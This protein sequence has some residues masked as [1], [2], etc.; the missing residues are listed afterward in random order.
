MA[1]SPIS[2]SVLAE[3]FRDP[4]SVDTYGDRYDR[5]LVAV[6]AWP[7]KLIQSDT[8]VSEVY[9]L[10]S[11]PEERSTS[12]GSAR[13]DDLERVLAQALNALGPRRETAPPSDVS[14]QVQQN[15]RELGYI[16]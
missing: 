12:S 13:S 9:D 10:S 8:G 3:A 4:F 6:L 15:L 11:N 7:G 1:T 2:S 14:P 16:D 5:D